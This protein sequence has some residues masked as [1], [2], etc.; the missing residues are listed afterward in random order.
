M[1]RAKSHN[2]EPNVVAAM[3]A[4]LSAIELALRAL[5][6]RELDALT[7]A[8][9]RVPTTL[10]PTLIAWL[11]AALHW[12]LNS[13]VGREDLGIPAAAIALGQERASID[14]AIAMRATFAR[15]SNAVRALFDALVDL[16]RPLGASR[17]DQIRS[18]DHSWL[19]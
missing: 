9:K 7:A 13:R 8:T 12:E 15:N 18:G 16:L 17:R 11:L 3:A 2:V 19:E 1:T 10:A 5:T 14:A 6:E 4:D